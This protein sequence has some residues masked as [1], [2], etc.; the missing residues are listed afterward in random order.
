MDIA[1]LLYEFVMGED[2]EIEVVGLP[3]RSFG[4]AIGN[5]KLERL[6]GLGQWSAWGF[7]EKEVHMFRH[8]DVTC[9]R[10]A[11]AQADAFQRILEKI[12]GSFCGEVRPSVV[13]AACEEVEVSGLVVTQPLTLHEC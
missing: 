9:D 1:K 13:A 6:H 7:A 11:I 12:P 10:V 5:R 8:D 4:A 2:V 3:E